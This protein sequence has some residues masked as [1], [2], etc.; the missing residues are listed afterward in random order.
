M[1]LGTKLNILEGHSAVIKDIQI[2]RQDLKNENVLYSL[3]ENGEIKTWDF[4]SGLVNSQGDIRISQY[5]LNEN[6]IFDPNN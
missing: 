3:S 5:I 6:S 4:D 1:K 2:I